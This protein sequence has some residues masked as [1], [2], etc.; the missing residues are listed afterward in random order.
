MCVHVCAFSY[1]FANEFAE[2]L[3]DE[4]GE[5]AA[6]VHHQRDGGDELLLVNRE[7]T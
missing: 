4:G 6:E 5:E 1:T 7:T 3:H 2:R